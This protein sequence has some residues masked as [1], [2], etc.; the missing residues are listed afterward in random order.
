M[1]VH[2]APPPMEWAFLTFF[3]Q[4]Y[5][6]I[7]L[8]LSINWKFHRLKSL[9]SRLMLLIIIVLARLLGTGKDVG[10]KRQRRNQFPF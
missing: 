7:L 5:P 8:E 3:S 10:C 4:N 1:W 2:A 6:S 9:K